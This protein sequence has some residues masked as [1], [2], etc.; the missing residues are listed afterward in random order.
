MGMLFN[1]AKFS[2]P[3]FIFIVGFHLIRQY[4]KQLAYAEYIYE[5]AAHLLIP[6]LFWSILYL[7]TT[8]DMITLQS[9]IKVYYSEQPHPIFGM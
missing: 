5:K 3:A 9:G 8:N 6:Y 4:T 2:A 1:L 7:L